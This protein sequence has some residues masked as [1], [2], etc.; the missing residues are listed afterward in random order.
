MLVFYLIFF[1]FFTI[2]CLF[3]FGASIRDREY[4]VTVFCSLLGIMSLIMLIVGIETMNKGNTQTVE[5]YFPADHYTFEQV[6]TETSETKYVG[7]DTVVVVKRDTTYKL[8]G[9]DPIIGGDK[10]FKREYPDTW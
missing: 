5:Y 7:N 8:V 10:H 4:G 2:L 9:Q 1:L 6:I 3:G